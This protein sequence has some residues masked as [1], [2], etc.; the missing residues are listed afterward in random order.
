M[1]TSGAEVAPRTERGVLE[2]A[3][4]EVR[5]RLPGDWSLTDARASVVDRR[6]DA[7][8]VLRAPDGAEA[9]VLVEAKMVVEARDVAAIRERLTDLTDS[10]PG[11]IGLVVARYLGKSV[12][13][14]LAKVGLSYADA[15]GNVLMSVTSPGLFIR[16]G[17]AESNPWRGPGRPRGTLKGEPA[18]KV[19][20]ALADL[21]G[22][23]RATELIAAS[24][25][26]AGSVYRVLEFLESEALATRDQNGRIDVPD[27]TALLRRWSEDYQFLRTNAVTGYIAPRGLP[28]FLERV[29]TDR[30][31]GSYAVTGSVAAAAWAAHAPAR[32]AMIYVANARD[33][34]EAWDLR[35]VDAGVN[36]LLA[37]PAYDVVFERTREALDGLRLAAPTQVAVDLMTGPGRAPSEA[38]ELLDWMERNEQSWR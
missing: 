14:R 34:A 7:T 1:V 27:W 17:G 32:S 29:R 6:V 5:E 16:D 11:S 4:S 24:G 31:P 37:E 35:P 28:D 26:S 9:L 36:V 3:V 22:P 18:A 15:T 20:R 21:P 19:V 10:F 23:W 38:E 13:Q 12:R 8:L 30:T 33:A 25:A 2:R